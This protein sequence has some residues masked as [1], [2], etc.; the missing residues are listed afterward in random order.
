MKKNYKHRHGTPNTII[1]EQ[2]KSILAVIDR[3]NAS[4]SNSMVIG[5]NGEVPLRRFLCEHLPYTLKAA[6]G[7]FITPTG[8]LSPQ[9]DILILDA[10][11][12]LLNINPDGSVLA[13]LHSVISTI[14]IKTNLTS[15]D[16]KKIC[17]DSLEIN[18]LFN[19]VFENPEDFGRQSTSAFAYRSTIKINTVT[20]TYSDNHDPFNM[21]LDL[22][23]MR[24][25]K[26]DQPNEEELGA[27]IHYEPEIDSDTPEPTSY[28]LI[29]IL[30]RTP[31]SDFYY[32][33]VQNSYYTLGSR[34]TTELDIGQH[35]MDYMAWSTYL[36]D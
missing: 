17:K 7:H 2:E 32:C 18:R 36:S 31:L 28:D 15:S 1:Q 6:S 19:E 14:E 34:N 10:R 20:S 27:L 5:N 16:I 23:I 25:H 26:S 35:L 29:S 21:D 30:Q 13:M 8:I 22:Y 11:Y 33:L 3:A 12:P 9:I 4:S 24:L